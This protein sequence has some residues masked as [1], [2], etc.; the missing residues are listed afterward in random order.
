MQNEDINRNIGPIGNFSQKHWVFTQ[1]H[2]FHF[3]MWPA[4]PSFKSHAARD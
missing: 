3:L 2:F 1:K 4:I